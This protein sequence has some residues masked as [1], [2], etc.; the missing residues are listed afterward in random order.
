MDPVSPTSLGIL[1]LLPPLITI[2][3]ALW[4]KRVIE[5]LFAG[6]AI[7]AWA[8]DYHASGLFHSLLYLVP[9]TFNVIAGHPAA[10]TLKGMGIVKDAGR[11]QLLVFIVLLG[12]FMTVLDHGG[13]AIDFA[14][15]ASKYIRGQVGA[16]LTSW[17]IGVCI[18]TSAYFSILVNGTVMRPIFDR[19]K[20]S[21]EKLAFFCHAM[22]VPT[23]ALLP[24]SGWIAYMVTLIEDNIP[25]V[26]KGSGLQAFIATMPYNFYSW[27]M[28]LF[29]FG[30]ALKLIPE[31]GPM[32][33]AEQRVAKEGLL[34]WPGSTP[35]MSE[36]HE[37]KLATMKKDGHMVDMI[38]P[39]A[40][41]V[42][43]LLVLGMWNH[44]NQQLALGLPKLP[45]DTTAIL[46]VGFAAGIL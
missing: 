28:P 43:F 41:S 4:T 3:L 39:V 21:R 18:I 8:L 10:E 22:S 16:M 40:I 2:V 13:G 32:R 9:N 25:G 20:I 31:Y 30:V 37:K 24:I 15:R 46:N 42:L 45:L 6:L 38:V 44:L 12:S 5:S 26:E 34:H 17:A 27:M 14:K 35:M 19:L 29:V 7:A 23:K 11:G 36:E 33:R 1:S